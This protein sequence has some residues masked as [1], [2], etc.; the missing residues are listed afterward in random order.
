[1]DKYG[2]IALYDFIALLLCVL[3]LFLS[4]I[5]IHLLMKFVAASLVSQTESGANMQNKAW[6]VSQGEAPMSKSDK[7]WEYEVL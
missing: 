1:M 7:D 2:F 4:A 3:L 5:L 6:G